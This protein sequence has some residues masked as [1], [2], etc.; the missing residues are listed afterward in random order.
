MADSY[1][2]EGRRNDEEAR[3]FLDGLDL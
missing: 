2:D 3:R 1:R